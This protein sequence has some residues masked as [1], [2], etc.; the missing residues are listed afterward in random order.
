[1]RKQVAISI[2]VVLT[3]VPLVAGLVYS[4]LYSLGMAGLLGKGFTLEHWEKLFTEGGAVSTLL[5]TLYLTLVSL[6]LALVPALIAAWYLSFRKQA[7][8]LY[9]VL[10]VPLTFPPLVA[11][12]AMFHLLNPGGILSRLGHAAGLYSEL[13]AF[14]RLVNDDWSIG[15]ILTHVF[16]IFPFFTLV[17]TNLARKENLAGLRDTARTL[18]AEG[19]QFIRKVFLPVLL[20]RGAALILLYGVFLF[21]TYEVPLLLG[22][23]D[24]QPVT[25]FITEKVARFDLYN[26]PVGHAMVVVYVV[27]TGAMVAVLTRKFKLRF[28]R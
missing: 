19:Q 18:G 20:K 23:Q 5:Y 25:V 17:F 1:M 7:S 22:R 26:I 16:L 3:V 12:F 4:L 11:A 15:I 27:L 24:P 2:F 14:P 9:G 10:F 6:V 8:N 21:G 28:D 13:D